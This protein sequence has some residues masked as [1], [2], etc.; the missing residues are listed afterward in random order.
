VKILLVANGF[1]PRER[2]GV[3]LD[4]YR[5]AIG[6]ATSH[7]VRVFVRAADLARADL[8]EWD[9]DNGTFQVHRL[10]RN[11]LDPENFVATFRVPA[12]D[13]KFRL[14][15]DR[16]RPDVVHFQHAIALSATM[17]AEVAS[18]G[19][20]S[21]LSLH[22]YWWV[23][24]RV[25]LLRPDLT[26]CSGPSHAFDCVRCLTDRRSTVGIE[27]RS[28]LARLRSAWA[29][30]RSRHTSFAD[31]A[32]V[33]AR[34]AIEVPFEGSR[35]PSDDDSWQLRLHDYR[36]ALMM[37]LLRLPSAIT[38]P[39][40]Y[41]RDYYSAA[42]GIPRERISV[43]PLGVGTSARSNG[44]RP[45]RSRLR[46]GYIGTIIPPK[47]VHVLAEAAARL[48]D[49]EL[50]F[51]VYGGDGGMPRYS[52]QLRAIAPEVCFHGSFRHED[53]KAVLGDLD[54]LVVPSIWPE[55]YS[56][57]AREAFVAG[58]PVIAS[59]IGALADVI[60]DGETGLLVEPGSIDDLVRALERLMLDSK[61]RSRLSQVS[62]SA[63]KV[64]DYVATMERLY[65]T[66]VSQYR[67]AST[68]S[69]EAM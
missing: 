46:V 47:G 29:F 57:V 37:N 66:V 18:A 25:Q 20:P 33:L 14:F 52:L 11:S 69:K 38:A 65:S 58:V 43:I 40:T 63:P 13:E 4:T 6:L 36:L 42:V 15:L 28:A 49:R 32:L 50:D 48:R 45:N 21:V 17:L 62:F 23:C 22:D 16:F 39:S 10:V 60:R 67:S 19:I 31:L 26:V 5:I 44:S 9:E 27:R 59:R 61:L 3:E 56:F 35:V 41:V 34:R 55:T 51:H 8:E 2:A 12:V 53:L 64:G 1:P 24:P 68:S 7:E 30:Q 54:V